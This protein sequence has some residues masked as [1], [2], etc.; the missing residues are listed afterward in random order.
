MRH[1]GFLFPKFNQLILKNM[2]KK[3]IQE[4]KD[5]VMNAKAREVNTGY[6]YSSGI[7]FTYSI[8]N[9]TA[10]FFSRLHD[11]S[12][13]RDVFFKMLLK[14]ARASEPRKNIP[15]KELDGEKKKTKEDL[16]WWKD[17]ISKMNN[18]VRV[19]ERWKEFG[20]KWEGIKF[21]DMTDIQCKERKSEHKLIKIEENKLGIGSLNIHLLM[22]VIQKI[23]KSWM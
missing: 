1:A 18:V 4:L 17:N 10:T 20:K 21:V 23:P 14:R 15:K 11:E 2:T 7:E 22:N 8:G 3:E 13:A 16:R 12:S 9:F 6:S 5:I 19:E